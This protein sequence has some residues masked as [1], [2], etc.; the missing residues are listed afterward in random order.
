MFNISAYC[1]MCREW[2]GTERTTTAREERPFTD[3]SEGFS[4]FGPGFIKSK[5]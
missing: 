5:N 4:D 2:D 3:L 1:K